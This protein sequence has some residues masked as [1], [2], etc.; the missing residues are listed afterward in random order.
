M[1]TP[2]T[3]VQTML[4]EPKNG[5]SSRTAVISTIMIAQPEQNTVASR[6]ATNPEPPATGDSG[7]EGDGLIDPDPQGVPDA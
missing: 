5:C 4:V 2:I 6:N 1:T 7:Q 3:F